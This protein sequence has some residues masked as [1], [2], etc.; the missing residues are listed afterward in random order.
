MPVIESLLGVKEVAKLCRVP[1]PTIWQWL[2]DEKTPTP[3]RMNGLVRFHSSKID[4]WIRQGCPTRK[5]FEDGD[6]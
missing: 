4:R 6:V 1:V 3:I 2:H 5:Q